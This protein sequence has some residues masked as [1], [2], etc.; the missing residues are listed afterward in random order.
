MRFG[1]PKPRRSY[2]PLH[3]QE[4]FCACIG[5]NYLVR[6]VNSLWDASRKHR[7]VLSVEKRAAE[8]VVGEA[9]PGM[10]AGFYLL[11]QDHISDGS[12]GFGAFAS[13][14]NSNPLSVPSE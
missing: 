11:E 12:G 9:W 14:F 10:T 4:R 13:T 7:S 2:L 1:E 6:V 3:A 5:F 8:S